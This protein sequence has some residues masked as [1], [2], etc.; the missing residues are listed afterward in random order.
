VQASKAAVHSMCETLQME[1]APF[2]ISVME[3]WAGTMKTDINSK[4]AADL[5]R[6]PPPL[7]RFPPGRYAP[8]PRP[9]KSLRFCSRILYLAT[10]G[11][12]IKAGP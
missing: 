10:A 3:V 1:L 9:K 11:V 4:V 7:L 8:P 2:G 12:D 6:L 5:D